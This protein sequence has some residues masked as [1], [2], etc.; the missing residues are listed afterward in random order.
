M[1][2]SLTLNTTLDLALFM[3]K[4]EPNKTI[5]A[6]EAA[7]S[8]GGKPA[9]ASFILGTLGTPSRALG[10]AAGDIGRK[11][12]SML[13]ARGVTPDFIEVDGETRICTVIVNEAEGWQTTI[14]TNMMDVRPEHIEQLRA[15][16]IE[17][18]E[19]ATVVVT[20][21]T[22]PR[23]MEASF[24]TEFIALARAKG[25][26]VVFDAAEP[27]LSAG[28]LSKPTYIK[29]NKDELEGLAGYPINTKE[30]AYR[31]GREIVER[32]GV[33]PI[34]SLGGEGGMAVLPDLAYYVP[35]LPIKVVSATGA[36]D[37]VLAGL[38]Y[39]L[40]KGQTPEEGIRLGFA[41]AAAVCLMPAT[42]DC[43][44]EDVERLLPQVELI[45]Y[46]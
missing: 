19:T 42:A 17:A 25:I 23:G 15:Q 7:L 36:G 1:I 16:F 13:R 37:G 26:P 38:T 30:D 34:I 10:F 45:P 39:S 44:P 46:P 20:G 40:Y 9:D 3:P 28:L 41:I 43:R 2:I 6:R 21:G 24:Y 18:L 31:A 12:A 5:R 35:P 22:L 8:M 33:S 27:N 32:Y 4:F 11:V 14:T 29:P